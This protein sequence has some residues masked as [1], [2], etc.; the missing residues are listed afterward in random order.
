[1][2]N[3][4]N[5][6][7]FED[8][9]NHP[10]AKLA[11]KNSVP[12]AKDISVPGTIS[13][14]NAPYRRELNKNEAYLLHVGHSL[15]HLLVICEQLHHI[16]YYLVT[17]CPSRSMVRAGITRYSHILMCMENYIVRTQSVFDRTLQLV[18]VL[19]NIYNPPDMINYSLIKNNL[20]I[21]NSK[22]GPELKKFRKLTEKYYSDRL[23]I[24]HREC[25]QEDDLRHLEMLT[26]VTKDKK[27]EYIKENLKFFSSI[28]VKEK[29][30]ELKSFNNAIFLEI[31][32]I[33]NHL[34]KRYNRRMNEDI[35]IYGEIDILKKT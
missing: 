7:S 2:S 29:A 25:Y 27:N 4:K 28:Y 1:M 13:K 6:K 16:P 8:L 15:S 14:V 12:I 19:F 20:H 26:V 21:K 10:F 24:I 30:N 17:F 31:D 35:L 32:N 22:L 18:N 23:K 3:K 5:I 33:F 9:T 11:F 34:L